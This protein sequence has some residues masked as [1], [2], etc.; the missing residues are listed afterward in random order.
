MGG[1]YGA[2]VFF[3]KP[4]TPDELAAI[5]PQVEEVCRQSDA[6]EVPL[7]DELGIVY[8]SDA[9]PGMIELEDHSQAYTPRL[10]SMTARGEDGETVRSLCIRVPYFD[11]R[12][13]GF[14]AT[15]AAQLPDSDAGLIMI[16]VSGA[17]GAMAK[18]PP[19]LR[20][21]LA[22]ELYASVSAICLFSSGIVGTNR[23]ETLQFQTVVIANEATRH[24]LPAWLENQLRSFTREHP[25]P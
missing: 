8:L 3:L 22:L 24:P 10:G 4:P 19:T 5:T 11:Q 13:H 2:E 20:D 14:L 9:P 25:A 12:S 6:D 17:P 18:W 15:E 23:G 16:Q 7:P 1:T 21:E